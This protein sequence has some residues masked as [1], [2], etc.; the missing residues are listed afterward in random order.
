MFGRRKKSLEP[1]ATTVAE[2]P[3]AKNR[4]T[5]KR[6]KAEAANRRPLVPSN[7][8]AASGDAKQAA[9]AERS[10]VREAMVTGDDRYLPPRDKGPV[11]R[12]ARDYVDARRN[13]GEYFLI[14]ALAVV[15]ISFVQT[16]QLQL[17]STAMLWLTVLLCF[18]DGFVLSRQLKKRLHAKFTEEQ[19]PSGIVR[20][21]VLR[22]FQIRRTRLPKPMVARGEYPT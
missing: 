20:Y 2:R 21:G 14:V 22:A 10:K 15:V 11:R 13:V 3:G 19:L 12:F 8:K 6:S 5:P 4:P 16:A 18:G 17:L 7:R 9:R 1:A